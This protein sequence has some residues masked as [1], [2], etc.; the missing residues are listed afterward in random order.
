MKFEHTHNDQ[1]TLDE[2][3]KRLARYRLSLNIGQETLAEEAGV[4]RSTLQRVEAGQPIKLPAFLRILRALDLMDELD[5]L[6]P[7]T[8]PSPIEDL[9]IQKSQRQRARRKK[10]IVDTEWEWAE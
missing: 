10:T 3:G 2:L 1:A 5:V 4:S 9:R 8:V 7:D 6:V